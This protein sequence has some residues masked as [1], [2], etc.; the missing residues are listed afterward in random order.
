MSG[1]EETS[2]SP[3]LP[4][5]AD[6]AV[7][8]AAARK[9]GRLFR[10]YA[11]SVIALVGAALLINSAFD[12]WFSYQE[13]KAA[14]VRVQQEKADAAAA[15]IEEFVNEIERQ[16]GWTTHAQWADGP[17]DQRRQD[18]F[19][20][21]RQVPA[22]TQLQ[23]LDAEGKEQL[24][25]SRLSMDVVGSGADFSQSPAFTQAKAHRIWFSPVYFRK[26][27]EP[28]MTLAIERDGRNAGVTIAE[29]NLKLIWDVITA[30]K[31]GEG[32]YA[33]VVDRFG[34]LI[35]HPDISL[36]L[37]D[38]D[39]SRLPQ[40][41]AALAAQPGPGAARQDKAPAVTVAKNLAGISVLTAH[42][43]IAP[44]G[45][46][47]FVEVPLAE[48]FAPLYGAALR[49]ALLLAL[50]LIAA[51]LVA[52]A[53][54][55]RM[56]GPIRAIA[57]G[58]ER[59]GAGELDRRIEIHTGDEIEALAEQFNHMAGDL[60]KSYAELEQRVA[61]RTAEL[62]ESLDQQTAT[63]EV[64]GVINSS[65]GDL[66]PVFDA[67]LEKA[68]RLCEAPF[69]VMLRFQDARFTVAASRDLPAPFHDYLRSVDYQPQGG[70]MLAR[71]QSGAPYVHTINMKDDDAYRSG[72]PLR[73]AAVD[74][75]GARHGLF[76][77]LRKDREL[78]GTFNL[79]RTEV[80]PFTERQIALLQNFA[81][82]AVIAM[83]N[84]RLITETREA[85]EQ[86]TA[87]AEVLQVINASPGDLAPVF[88][89]MLDK[90]T[91]L[92]EAIYGHLWTYD[93][94]HFHPV[95]VHGE[96]R[97]GEWV[98]R[99]GAVLAVP[100]SP[101]DRILRGERFVQITDAIED[102]LY[103]ASSGYRDLVEISGS[104]TQ[105]AVALRKDDAIVGTI[106][107]Y[108]QEVRPF[109]DKQI[110]LLQ[111][112]AA[113]AVIAMENARLITETR[114]ALDQQTATAEVL[115]II[116]SSP[117]DLAP[118]FDAML[119]KATRLCEASFGGLTRVDGDCFHG[120]AYHNAPAA[121]A[122][123]MR[124]PRPIA[125]GNAHYRLLN[126][127]DVVQVADITAEE[128][129]RSG[130][131]ARRSLADLAGAR[132]VLWAALR[133]DNSLLGSFVIYRREVRP[134]TD[135]QIALLQNFA[136][137]AVI[138][139]ENARLITETREALDQQTATA[140]VLQV[141]NSSPGDLTPVFDAMLDKAMRLC[142]AA[143]GSFAS[144]DGEIFS[145][146]AHRN[147]PAALAEV[148]NEPLR[149]R[150][151]TGAVGGHLQRLIKGETV[152]AIADFSDTD[153]YRS[154]LNLAVALVEIGGARSAVWVALRKDEALLGVLVIYRQEV[155]P[156]TDKQIALL[157]NF[158]A[159]AVIAME[160]A[161]LIT[162]TREAL[163]QQTAT[164]E[165]LGV[166]NASPGDLAPVF[167]AMLAKATSLCDAS[168]G[169]METF[170][171]ERLH[172]AA[173]HRL[174]TGLIESCARH[175]R[176]SR[177]LLEVT[178]SPVHRSSKSATRA[179]PKL[180]SKA[181]RCDARS[182]RSAV[183]ARA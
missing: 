176:S 116:N 36:V 112:F 63:A 129:Y 101:F 114:E 145:G 42:A 133:K 113:Q 72:A 126:G 156:F 119:E 46:R 127:E 178:C 163:E 44:L 81:A 26:Q 47:V 137:Q 117:G 31:I 69:G 95:A 75:A 10:K 84:A 109:S 111:N 170:D 66:A 53:L 102:D 70:V 41:A 88:E 8:A 167:D 18:Y 134:F 25:V 14:L 43:A 138:A 30:L 96:P 146:I 103:R 7:G 166:I 107:V 24:K 140:E 80:R 12:F 71:L 4:V 128:I 164:A 86:Q 65:P 76:V 175:S 120:V 20:L 73:R 22:I 177:G 87:T 32:G 173:T 9:R 77:S 38:T 13:N 16:I 118:V 28:Y 159:Q 85:L 132:T 123:A 147:V 2:L 49:T 105:L 155:R 37:R 108:R 92:C 141:I 17:L 150:P 100:S 59:I 169:V 104:R 125:P 83:E 179:I 143:F 131:P 142:E 40:V 165:V 57:A 67:M 93:G 19:R 33:Y 27:S 74:L 174:P 21:L 181:L 182:S 160:N 23:Q 34:R 153:A 148:L 144:F 3:A 157:Q 171:G 6:R 183:P 64:L 154:G 97:F 135:K 180:G 124:E 78:L 172:T 58:A 50:A 54:A 122:E 89:A 15:R 130:N 39:L 106:V 98:F 82:Q 52:L 45:W 68:L 91:R 61:D 162:E 29:I 5:A 55:R 79:W 99:R 139:M 94:Q 62:S 110:A 168:F 136:A 158:A 121:L 151:E 115:G 161:R 35:A 48:A 1:A 51:T 11:L 90:A 60:Q 56:T 149:H 152:V